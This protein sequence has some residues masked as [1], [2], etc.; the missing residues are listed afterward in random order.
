MRTTVETV[1]K[2]YS[3]PTIHS[4]IEKKL[5]SV[6][7]GRSEKYEDI[8]LKLIVKNKI[9][10]RNPAVCSEKGLRAV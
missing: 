5:Q 6:I 9:T 7:S 8:Q 1:I 4:A 3:F 2:H 10:D